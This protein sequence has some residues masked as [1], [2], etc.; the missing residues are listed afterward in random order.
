MRWV[1]GLR[2]QG[3]EAEAL[4]LIAISP[5]LEACALDAAWQGLNARAA[6]MFVSGNAVTHFFADRSRPW[7]AAVRALA[8]GPGTAAALRRCGVPAEGVD[9]PPEAAAQFDSEA[10]WAHIGHR[11][12]QGRRVLIVRGQG[13]G[14]AASS[15]RDW[16]AGQLRQAG[17]EVDLLA[18][19]RR[20]APA[21]TPEQQQ[22]MHRAQTDGSVWLLSSSEAVRHL[23]AE[24]DWTGA[25]ALATHARI[26]QALRAAGFG[27]VQ[28]TRPTLAD[29]AASIKSQH[30]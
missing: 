4:P 12:W 28:E 7:P 15:G 22:R 20:S 2:S 1:E 26:A 23:P 8:T 5:V 21:F 18:V 13:D 14:E 30:P 9:A 19:Y 6:V 3:L 10:L 11:P 29:V 16:L 27:Q 24:L 25:R 17:A